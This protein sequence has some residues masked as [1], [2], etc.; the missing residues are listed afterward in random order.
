VFDEFQDVISLGDSLTGTIRSE[1]EQH[2]DAAGYIFSGSHPGM[3]R[4]LFTSRRRAFFGQA[5]P[6]A[7]GPLDAEVLGEEIAARFAAHARDV[8]GALDPILSLSGGHPQRALLLAHHVFERTEPGV[9]ADTDTWQEA[10]AD[11]VVRSTGKSKVSGNG[12][13][14]LNASCSRS[15]QTMRCR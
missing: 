6:I 9:V 11:T 13:V 15:S 10:L 2:G 14:P 3:M 1:L 8:G 12:S 4:D 7:V 5:T